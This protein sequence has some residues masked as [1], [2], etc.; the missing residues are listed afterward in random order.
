MPSGMGMHLSAAVFPD[1]PAGNTLAQALR[2]GRGI[3]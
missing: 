2:E 3:A 1:P